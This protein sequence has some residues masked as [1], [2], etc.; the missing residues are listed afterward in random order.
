VSRIDATELVLCEDALWCDPGDGTLPTGVCREPIA[1]GEPC[2]ST[3]DIC[4]SGDW[5]FDEV[6]CKTAQIPRNAGDACDDDA[7]VY[8][9]PFEA[10]DCVDNQ[11]QRLG[12][13]SEGSGCRTGDFYS[14]VTCNHG[15]WCDS[16]ELSG[17]GVCRVQV[18]GGSACTSDRQCESGTCDGTCAESFC[19]G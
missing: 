11:C 4:V 5:C 1:H 18:A 6:S 10:L 17:E 3:N 12:D 7:Y 16:G 15:L 2:D 19:G 8:C 14:S 13:G 9:D